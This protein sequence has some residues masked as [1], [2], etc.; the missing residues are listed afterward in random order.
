MNNL[1]KSTTI[2]KALLLSSTSRWSQCSQD[3]TVKTFSSCKM[4]VALKRAGCCRQELVRS[5]TCWLSAT[6][7]AAEQPGCW[8]EHH[9]ERLWRPTAACSVTRSCGWPAEGESCCHEQRYQLSREPRPPDTPWL[10]H[11]LAP[12]RSRRRMRPTWNWRPARL[13]RLFAF[14]FTLPPFPRP[15][16][17]KSNQLLWQFSKKMQW[18]RLRAGQVRYWSLTSLNITQMISDN[19]CRVYYEINLRIICI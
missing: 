5:S 8:A 6:A 15:D 11:Q 7:W 19:H 4:Q 12:L 1:L 16:I 3:Q 13:D 17:L 2:K 10:W 14:P 9:P 18:P